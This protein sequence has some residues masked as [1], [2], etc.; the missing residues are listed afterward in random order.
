MPTPDLGWRELAERHRSD[1]GHDV[2]PQEVCVQLTSAGS[3]VAVLEPLG[4]V[5]GDRQR[6]LSR[7]SLDTTVHV[8]RD[9]IEVASGISPV[10][11]RVLALSLTAIRSSI[12]DLIT[13]AGLMA[14][15]AE[16]SP[17]NY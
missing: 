16:A 13:T 9:G 5:D 6:S 4:R 2:Q 3:E 11:E 14:D 8:R 12:A 17:G 15:V 7:V 10:D 1:L